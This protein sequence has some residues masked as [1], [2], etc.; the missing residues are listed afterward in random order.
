MMQFSDPRFEWRIADIERQLND[1][2]SKYETT[3]ADRRL[4]RLESALREARSQIDGL[5]SE[6]EACQDQV[7]QLINA[8][9]N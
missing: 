9:F 3:E 2:Q 7:I 6:L 1:K 4:D 5:R 8:P